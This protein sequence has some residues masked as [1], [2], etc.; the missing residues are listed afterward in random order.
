MITGSM[1]KSKTKSVFVCQ[2]CGAQRPRW[3]GRCS[4]CGEWNSLVEETQS[5]P[6]SGTSRSLQTREGGSKQIYK[7]NAIPEETSHGARM[8]SQIGELD[9]VLGGGLVRGSFVLLGGEPG[10][11]KSTL[12]LQMAQGLAN[13]KSKVLYLSAEESVAQTSQ[14]ARRLGTL[15]ADIEIGAE[16]NLESIMDMA[17]SRRPDILVIDS[18][19]TVFLPSITSAPGSVSQVREC[20]GHLMTLA[21]SENI[22]VIVI[23]HVTKDGNLAGP[24]VLEHL[25]DTVLS[26]EGDAHHHF[27]ILRAIKN[28]FGATHELGIFQMASSGLKEVPNPSELFLEERQ[29]SAIGSVVF[30]SIEGSRPLLCEVQAL[31]VKSPMPM[32]R[33]NSIGL[34]VNRTH[35]LIAVLDRHAGLSLSQSDV[36]VNVVGGLKLMEPA[37]D[38]AVA[39]ALISSEHDHP[40]DSQAC[41]FGEI[42]L[43]GEVRAVPFA[44]LRIKEA[45]KLGFKKFYMPFSNKKHLFDVPE[46]LVKKVV[47]VKNVSQLAQLQVSKSS[48][49]QRAKPLERDL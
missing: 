39:A 14:R 6:T 34:E 38:L 25:V 40:V 15:Q 1:A 18:I 8:S 23:G 27:R 35:L 10:I 36:F 33:R 37:A 19:Q 13:G 9:R 12:V 21:K 2:S 44:D 17:R 3:E 22:S 29:E 43:S 5:A 30:A 16:N 46:D 31:T 20:A 32:P 26:F 49:T 4:D 11:G 45:A 41:Y 24:K 47:W 42:G 48:Q 7:L 28:R